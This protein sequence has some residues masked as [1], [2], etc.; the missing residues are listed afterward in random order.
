[1]TILTTILFGM[2]LALLTYT[3][4][5]RRRAVTAVRSTTRED[6]A[7]S[8]L[9]LARSFFGRNFSSWNSYLRQPRKYLPVPVTYNNF[10]VGPGL[11]DPRDPLQQQNLLNTDPQ[12]FADLDGDGQM[13]VYFYIRDNEDELPPAAVD[14]TRDNDQTV[15]VGS[16]C[17]SKT[18]APRQENGQIASDPLVVE[19]LLSYNQTGCQYNQSATSNGTG[20][21]NCF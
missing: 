16:F 6:C 10:N 20:N 9:Q 15:I 2:V 19:G 5:G 17:I 3:G 18:M 1:V 14:F 8:G 4:Q 7:Q 12:L 13:D 11:L 21:Q